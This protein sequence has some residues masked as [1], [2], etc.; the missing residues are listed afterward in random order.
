MDPKPKGR[1]PG[2]PPIKLKNCPTIKE[3]ILE[4]ALEVLSQ[5]GIR[6]FSLKEVSLRAQV[7]P[8]AIYYHFRSKERLVEETLETYLIPVTKSLMD[9]MDD[10]DDPILMIK[11]LQETLITTA[12]ERPW[13]LLLWNQELAN[14]EKPMRNYLMKVTSKSHFLKFVKKIRKGQETGILNPDLIPEM[15]YMTIFSSFY[16]PFLARP[17]WEVF[18][19]TE[20]PIDKLFRHIQSASLKGIVTEAKNQ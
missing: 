19:E 4:K 17:I 6:N 10:I 14:V 11:S 3:N 16:I 20:I 1:L 5:E 9:I 8:A 13:F 2:R 12:I 7:T 18:F 15:L